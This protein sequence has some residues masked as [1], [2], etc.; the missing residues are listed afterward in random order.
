MKSYI[1]LHFWEIRPFTELQNHAEL[2]GTI[3]IDNSTKNCGLSA[4]GTGKILPVLVWWP[5]LAAQT[6]AVQGAANPN[7]NT[8]T[9]P[10]Y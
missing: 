9:L 5:N 6:R 2:V 10:E 7:S 8:K 4:I 1:K 3:D